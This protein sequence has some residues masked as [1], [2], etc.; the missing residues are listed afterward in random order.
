MI[1]VC[2]GPITSPTVKVSWG[3]GA[4]GG[5]VCVICALFTE[6]H[7]CVHPGTV[8][9]S[10]V[11]VLYL[12]KVVHVLRS[13]VMFPCATCVPGFVNVHACESCDFCVHVTCIHCV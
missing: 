6:V 8:F 1:C 10:C 12:S 11:R 4:E 13:H 9:Y 3:G 5:P 7:S 2:Q